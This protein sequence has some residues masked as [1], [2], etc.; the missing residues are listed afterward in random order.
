[1]NKLLIKLLQVFCVGFMPLHF[2]A[3]DWAEK[4]QATRMWLDDMVSA[5]IPRLWSKKTGF[6]DFLLNPSIN[7]RTIETVM[8]RNSN[9]DNYR[10]VQVRYTPHSGTDDLVT[11]EASMNCNAVDQ[12]RDTIETVAPSLVAEAKFTLNEQFVRQNAENGVGLQ[13]RINREIMDARR[14]L[15][16]SIDSQ[17]LTA[18][19]NAK[20]ANPAAGTG[21]AA[22]ESIGLIYAADGT[23]DARTFDRFV[24]DME[25][26][27]VT[28]PFAMVG[29]GQARRYFNR[30]M[31]GSTFSDDGLNFQE[32][33]SQFGMGFFKDHHTT[34]ALGGADRVLLFA[35]GLAQYFQYN[36]WSGEFALNHGD[37][38]KTTFNDPV[39]PIRYDYQIRYDDNCSTGTGI[40]GAWTHRLFVYFDL[41]T[42]PE[43]AWGDTYSAVNDFNG[44]VGYNITTS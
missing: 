20:G 7:P 19:A 21:A 39:Y 17:L 12:K 10:D 14:K 36:H 28:G 35:P 23:V 44:I 4:L 31:V 34:A 11:A 40:N 25:D 32:V 26:N 3:I 8:L 33:M 24:N 22:W 29:L 18:A 5:N 37:H 41:Y 6:L 13:Q 16:E 43:A 30:L 15:I 27:Y 9:V 1:M 42:V 2:T 38:I